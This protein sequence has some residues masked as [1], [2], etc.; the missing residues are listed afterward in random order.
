MMTRSAISRLVW[1]FCC[2]GLVSGCS[3]RKELYSNLSQREANEIIVALQ[4]AG[5]SADKIPGPENTFSVRI[6]NRCFAEA[7]RV[8]KSA[9]LPKEKHPKLTE[10]FK[11][12]GLVS[13]P[14]EERIRFMSALADEIASTLMQIDGVQSAR[15]HIVLPDNDPFREKIQPSS[16]AV[17]IQYRSDIPMDKQVAQI[18]NLVVN[19]IEGLNYDRVSVALF[20]SAAS[21]VRVSPARPGDLDH[22]LGMW[23][24][25]AV[26]VG[27]AAI[28]FGLVRSGLLAVKLETTHL[29]SLCSQAMEWIRLKTNARRP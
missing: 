16:A 22:A 13:S 18:K 4:E 27:L 20:P 1:I 3:D 25:L 28:G 19:S 24:P 12:S 5:L 14:S 17:F 23:L 9:G 8:L 2:A 10:V 21:P 26:L 15:V 6:A 11:K 7:V 29:S